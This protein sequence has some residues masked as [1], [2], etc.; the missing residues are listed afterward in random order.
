MFC[1][2]ADLIANVQTS[3]VLFVL[4]Q[5]FTRGLPFDM[6]YGFTP[7]MEL[8]NDLSVA[9]ENIKMDKKKSFN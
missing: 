4:F 7:G 9:V 3:S 6:K 1:S 8:H 5:S 2:L